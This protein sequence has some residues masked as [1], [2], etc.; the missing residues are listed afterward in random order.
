MQQIIPVHEVTLGMYIAELDRPWLG[1]NFPIQGFYVREH[2]QITE[3]SDVCSFVAVDPRRYDKSAF[4]QL[5]YSTKH[6]RALAKRKKLRRR[7]SVTPTEP[8]AYQDSLTQAQEFPEAEKV[9]TKAVH[10]FEPL[11]VK[12]GQNHN[13]EVGEVQG[14][15]NPLVES[16]LRNK[17]ALVTLMRVKDFDQ[18]TYY[19]CLTN[20]VWA[21]LM[22]RQLGFSPEQIKRL[23]LGCSLMDV[24]RIK[25]PKEMLLRNGALSDEEW[26]IIHSHVEHS[27]SLIEGN[28]LHEDVIGVVRWHHERWNGSGYPD[29]LVGGEIPVFARIA[30]V[31]DSYNA[32]TRHRPFAKARSSFEAITTLQKNCPELYQQEL[33]EQFTQTVG[34]FPN[35]AL[36]ELNTGEVGV[37]I[38]QNESRR[39]RPELVLVLDGDKKPYA[40]LETTKLDDVWEA[41]EGGEKVWISKELAPGSYG[42]DA[43]DYFL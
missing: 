9:L 17:D 38:K 42:I 26:P 25:L 27:L 10:Q 19:H 35:G 7:E 43:R 24:G 33:V 14:F 8:K 40:D 41:D 20:A 37:V 31:V 29:H 6:R 15:I 1:T 2:T 3:L 12:L 16:V 36:V 11:M 22:G 13:V 32:M 5:K 21:S 39:L 23:A 30:G 18:N 34:I 28:E 4:K